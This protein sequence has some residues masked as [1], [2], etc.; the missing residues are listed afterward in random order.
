MFEKHRGKILFLAGMVAALAAGWRGFPVVL[1]QQ[2]PQP[3][4][5]SH[6]VHAEK[7]GVKC[8][9]CHFLREDGTFT[10]VPVLDKCSGC[11][12][13]AMGAT[14]KEKNFIAR[15]VTPNREIPWKV[16]SRQPMNVWFSHAPH[17]KLAKFECKECHGAHGN[18]DKLRPYEQNRISGYS[19][20]IWGQSIAR[21]GFE[22]RRTMKMDDCADCHR[23][24][25]REHSCMECHK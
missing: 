20:D 3:V 1:Y 25:G 19:R 4:D 13:Q 23:K 18:T 2:V 9:D 24:H 6:R 14:L 5:F 21:V 22:P 8:E 10:G 16:Y 17:I 7:A 15:Y 12:A 11:H